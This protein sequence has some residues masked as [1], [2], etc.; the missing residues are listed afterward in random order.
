MA[1]KRKMPT[2]PKLPKL[3]KKQ[4]KINA[5]YTTGNQD[6]LESRSLDV[7]STAVV[8]VVLASRDV[9]AGERVCFR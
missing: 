3:D 9:V 8:F 2:D 7:R 1:S 4:K 5:I 6:I